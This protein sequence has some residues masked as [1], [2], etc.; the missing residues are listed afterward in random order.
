MSDINNLH[1]G[2]GPGHDAPSSSTTLRSESRS[3]L[4]YGEK[5]MQ[6][7]PDTVSEKGEDRD[8]E[9]GNHDAQKPSADE[10][11]KE[12]ESK[13]PNLIEWNGPN[14]PENPQNMPHW[15]K[16]V[17][18]MTMS[19]M[20]MWLTFA[21]SV[22]STAT[23]VTAQQ[24]GVSTEVMIL[25]TSLVVFGFAAGPLVWSPMSELY[26]RK[27]PLF[28]GY[29]LFAIFQIPVAVAKNVQ[30]ILVCRFLMGFLG[31]S[32]LAVVG[33]AMADFWDPVDR[34]IAIALFSAATF[35]GPVL[36]PIV[37]GFLTDSYLGWR[38]TAW[39][40][41][42]ASGS[43][44]G[45]AWFVVPETYHPVLLQRRAAKL[46]KET[47][48]QDLYAF[49][50]HHRPTFGDIVRKYLFRPVQ[51][52]ML[53]PILILI[54]LYLALVYGILYLFFEAYPVSF[55][56]E[57]GWTNGGIAGLPFIGIMIGVLCGVA[58]IV[59]QTKTRFAR[60][61]AKHGR[62]I[63]EERLVP[64]MVA[65]VLLP[66]GLFW[67]GWTS[68]PNVHW[69]AQVAAGVPIGAG[70]LV[71]FMQGLNYII[72]VYM[73]FA[74][75]AIAANTLIRSSLGGAFPL[76]ATQ[77]YHKLGVPWASS[78]LGFITVAMIPIPIVFYIYGKKIR[79]LSKF[80]PNF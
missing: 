54:T 80:S 42:I 68:S 46:R 30:T 15:R 11:P 25:A 38:W 37:G 78:L 72:D 18:T 22:F 48:N 63:P 57:R 26:G 20:T 51:M 27:Y 60:K 5:A 12:L 79:A 41:L 53:E 76:F 58:L 10:K 71:I 31:C 61:L 43:F 65:S 17:I 55:Q 7:S 4:G 73:M 3:S 33:G 74:N 59:W 67:F 39:I 44:G 49:L 32:P 34:A 16:W 9:S 52:L 21:S 56:E 1:P 19:S 75:S 40:T 77:M 64:M 35:V 29:A 6:S 70:I 28:L 62:V 14:D 45:I 66:G 8:I 24:F 23:L 36:G 13:D 69:L 47:G 50:D 2:D